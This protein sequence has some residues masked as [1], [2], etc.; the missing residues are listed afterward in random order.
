[1]LVS[2]SP[3]DPQ[4]RHKKNSY[5]FCLFIPG[6]RA[7]TKTSNLRTALVEGTAEQS[8]R[9]RRRLHF[10]WRLT[11]GETASTS[12]LK[13]SRTQLGVKITFSLMTNLKTGEHQTCVKAR[14]GGVCVCALSLGP[15][16]NWGSFT[17]ADVRFFHTAGSPVQLLLLQIF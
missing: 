10:P 15:T 9:P 4:I 14:R 12:A 17:L 13:R 16:G 11:G 2:I 6:R 3:T 5:E 1:M 8:R 7:V